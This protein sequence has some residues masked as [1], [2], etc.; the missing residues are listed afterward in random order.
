MRT[1]IPEEELKDP[2]IAR[3][4]GILRSC[5]HCGMCTATC[6]S[7]QILGNEL[8]SPRGRIYLIK[9]ML[10]EGRKPDAEMVEHIDRCLSCLACTTTC[11]SGVDYM[12][13]IDDTRDYIEEHYQRPLY[14]RGLRTLLAWL[15]PYPARFRHAM[16]LARLAR[17]FRAL[18]WGR[19]RAMLELTPKALPKAV[20]GKAAYPVQSPIKARVALLRGCAQPVLDPKIEAATVELLNRLGVEVFVPPKAKCCGA[21]THHM[22]KAEHAKQFAQANIDAWLELEKDAPLDAII[23]NTSGCGTVIKDY[24]HMLS[25]DRARRVSALTKDITEFLLDIYP[26]GTPRE[27]IVAYHAACSL[28]HG[29][30]VVDA[31]KALLAR[32]GFTVKTPFEPH[33]CCGSAGTY[34]IMQPDTAKQLGQRKSENLAKLNADV[35][36][37]GNIGCMTQIGLYGDTPIV[38]TV[39][40]LNWAVGGQKPPSLVQKNFR[41]M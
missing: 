6:P 7:Y 14:D 34:N 10:E 27:K 22:G 19:L 20:G 9:S 35:I 21:L 1:E 5:V 12:H 32:A 11:P 18:S 16:N 3:A 41:K 8:D 28:Q 24:G 4:E 33:L 40:L 2:K 25:T 36:A 13:L 39:E 31:P 15:L 17:P 30:K 37:A 26:Q 23:V 38:H 29:Q